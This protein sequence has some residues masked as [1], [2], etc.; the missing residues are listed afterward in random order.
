MKHTHYNNRKFR[1][2]IALFGAVYV[3]LY[4]KFHLIFEALVSPGFYIAVIISFNIALLLVN[5]IHHITIWLDKRY[6]WR[7]NFTKRI[8]YQTT[9]GVIVPSFTD[10]LLISI[11]FAAKGENILYNGFLW[12]DF[13]VVVIF[14]VLLNIYYWRYYIYLTRKRYIRESPITASLPLEPSLLY[15]TNKEVSEKETE[16]SRESSNLPISVQNDELILKWKGGL[17]FIPLKNIESL[18]LDNRKVQIISLREENYSFT[19]SI[20]GTLDVI[21]HTDFRQINRSVILSL[22]I[23]K[24]Y[25]PGKRKNTLR[26][27]LK[28][29]YSHIYNL[30][31]KEK[32]NVTKEFVDSIR[33]EFPSF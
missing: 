23:I 6:D 7:E 19:G 27:I 24:G 14:L 28:P 25:K 18:F 9:L 31:P 33:N 8:F 30:I 2:L 16:L 1:I 10:L 11:Y 20:T 22:R 13:P 5:F 4:D 32:F 12:I 3:V 15:F 21:G 29:K 17:V 26:I